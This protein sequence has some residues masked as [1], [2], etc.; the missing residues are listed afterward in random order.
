MNRLEVV[1]AV[2]G[3]LLLLKNSTIIVIIKGKYYNVVVNTH[4][5]IDL[6]ERYNIK[7]SPYN[8]RRDIENNNNSIKLISID[9]LRN[10]LMLSEIIDPDQYPIWY[11]PGDTTRL[12]K[13]TSYEIDHDEY[14]RDFIKKYDEELERLNKMLG[15]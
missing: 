10:G 15:V 11:I 1:D 8:T 6:F 7:I 4:L 9:E 13:M 14:A 2:A 5:E 12:E 3:Q